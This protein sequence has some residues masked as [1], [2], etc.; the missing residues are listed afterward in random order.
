MTRVGASILATFALLGASWLAGVAREAVDMTRPVG[1]YAA[2]TSDTYNE[3][4]K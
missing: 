3:G 4:D 2:N 1:Q